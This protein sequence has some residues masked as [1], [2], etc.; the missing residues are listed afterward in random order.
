MGVLI[1]TNNSVNVN[2]QMNY[3]LGKSATMEEFEKVYDILMRRDWVIEPN[4]NQVHVINLANRGWKWGYDHRKTRL[5]VC[6]VRK[7]KILISKFF[8][9]H[10]LDTFANALEDTV[11]HEIA[12]ALDAELRGH[13]DHGP[14]WK[15]IAK[16]VGAIPKAASKALD[17][18]H[19]WTLKCP[20]C[21]YTFGRH[22][23]TDKAT[24]V[25][26]GR[27]CRKKNKGKFSEE[28]KFEIIQNF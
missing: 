8:L 1:R 24:R 4:K 2:K 25:A 18:E 20:S 6:K 26:C 22:R 13:S 27:C 3:I 19:K 23:L 21:G 7:K 10:N 11:R 5:G 12:H 14:Q 15:K 17:G 16:Q 28:Y 9:K